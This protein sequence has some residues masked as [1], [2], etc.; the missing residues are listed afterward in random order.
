MINSKHLLDL[1]AQLAT[2]PGRG[3]PRQTHLRRAVSTAYYALFHFLV[4]AAADLLVGQNERGGARYSL[5]YRSFDH[6]EMKNSCANAA[7]LVYELQTCA[8][9]FVELQVA[10]H[11][12]DY[13]PNA[14]IS[15]HD[16]TAAIDKAREAMAV[17]GLAEQNAKRLFLTRLRFR[18]RA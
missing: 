4:A 14:R 5:V 17:F 18:P 2:P 13:E 8:R 9:L 15:A 11:E 7:S 12:A 16:A 6:R 1:A 10:R 3:R